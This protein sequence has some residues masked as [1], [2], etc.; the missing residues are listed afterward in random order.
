MSIKQ[1]LQF[2]AVVLQN[3]PEM[4]S[5]AMQ[6]HIDNPK[7]LQTV[8]RKALAIFK[9]IKLGT[10]L[11]TTDDFRQ[12]LKKSGMDLSDW[13]SDLLSQLAFKVSDKPIEVD[14]VTLTVVELGLER[15]ASYSDI[16]KRGVELGYDLCKPEYGPQLRL[17]YKDQP[18][19]EVLILA[20][21][22][23]RNSSGGLST[24]AVEHLVDGLW[25]S[26]YC[27]SPDSPYST[28]GRFVFACRK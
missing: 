15:M 24:F 1:A 5:E 13:A 6:R 11:K 4:S 18:K 25:L 17:Q 21:E 7:G 26:S 8:L 3:L 22:S 23:I 20:M 10:G 12:A 14:L 19:G 27:A 16:C 28:G 9:T 2:G